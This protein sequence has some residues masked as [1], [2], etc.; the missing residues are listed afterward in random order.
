[1]KEFES[2]TIRTRSNLALAGIMN[3]EDLA[4]KTVEDLT[5]VRN[6]GQKSLDEILSFMQDQGYQIVD[7]R[8]VKG[9]CGPDY[10]QIGGHDE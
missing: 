4:E 8:F 7:G 9:G 6:L 5:K 3:I 1:M 10:C 2:M